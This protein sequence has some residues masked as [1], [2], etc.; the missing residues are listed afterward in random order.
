[1]KKLVVPL[2][3]AMLLA[4]C[5]IPQQNV[6]AMDS[7]E[8]CRMHGI[9]AG[10]AF[11]DSAAQMRDEILRRKLLSDEEWGLVQSKNIR[12]GMSQCA[13]YASWG[14]PERENRTVGSFGSSIQHVYGRYSRYSRPTYVYTRNGVVNSFQD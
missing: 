7:L 14:R 3:S 1:L 12:V 6:A 8:V 4:A 2:A 13:M 11:I 9:Y 5:A 10:T